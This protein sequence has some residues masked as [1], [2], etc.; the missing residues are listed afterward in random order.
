M[1][2]FILSTP[3]GVIAGYILTAV[4]IN[5]LTWQWAFYIMSINMLLL[6]LAMMCYSKHYINYNLMIK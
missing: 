3:L 4:V 6:A 1:S 5:A 2:F